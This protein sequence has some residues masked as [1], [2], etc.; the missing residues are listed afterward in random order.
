MTLDAVLGQVFFLPYFDVVCE[1]DHIVGNALIVE[2]GDN[3][4]LK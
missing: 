3:L 4:Q 1:M 2:Y